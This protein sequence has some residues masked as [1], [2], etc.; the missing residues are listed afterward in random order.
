M[1]DPLDWFQAA[2]L[3]SLAPATVKVTDG[4]SNAFSNRQGR[5]AVQQQTEQWLN[6][7]F[8]I[9]ACKESG[10]HTSHRDPGNRD[11]DFEN[12]KECLKV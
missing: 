2:A 3:G 11:N 7:C 5:A 10:A 6:V 8:P 9:A 1:G 12:R 4:A